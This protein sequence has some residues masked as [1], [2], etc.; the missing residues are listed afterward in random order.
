VE[1]EQCR[2][3]TDAFV[4]EALASSMLLELEAP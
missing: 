4:G 1:E 2:L 3:E